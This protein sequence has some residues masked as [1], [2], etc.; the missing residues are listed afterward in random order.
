LYQVVPSTSPDYNKSCPPRKYDPVMAKKLLAEAGYPDGFNFKIFILDTTWKDGWVAIQGY[1]NKV[2][3]KMDINYVNVA[4]MNLIRTGGKIEKGAAAF[5][6]FY[7]SSNSLYAFDLSW[8]SGSPTHQYV[9]RPAGIDDLIDK[10]KLS[11]DPAEI[12]KINQQIVKLLYDDVTVVPVWQAPRIAVTDK[13]V[14]NTGWFI[15]NDTDNNHMG[16][17]TW[18]KK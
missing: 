6:P 5:A 2:G 13:I 16:T 8:R 10:A 17:R 12:T 15:Y 1:L 14:Q 4:N 3:I 9:V 7:S 18:L 11:R